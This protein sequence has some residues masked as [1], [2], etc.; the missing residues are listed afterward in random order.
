MTDPAER[1]CA[2]PA[3]SNPAEGILT[4]GSRRHRWG[5]SAICGRCENPESVGGRDY[6]QVAAAAGLV[7][8]EV[9]VPVGAWGWG[10]W[11]AG[12]LAH[13]VGQGYQV[14]GGGWGWGEV[15]VVA[16]QVPA[17][18]GGEAAGVGFAQVVRVG[19][20]ERRQGADD[21]RRVAV[22]VGQSGDRLSGTAV[23]GA[24]PW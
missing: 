1:L 2:V 6:S 5:L 11:G 20:G 23:P 21:S 17:S 16:D 8:G 24:A 9:G 10:Q 18:G 4:S 19:L 12:G 14:V 22:D 7:A 3:T 13:R 15:A